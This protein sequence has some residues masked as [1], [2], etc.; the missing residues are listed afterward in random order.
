MEDLK[1][2][3][4][5]ILSMI[6]I[7]IK[8]LNKYYMDYMDIKYT[9]S[10]KGVFVWI[11]ILQHYRSYYTINIKYIYHRILN[12]LGQKMV[13]LFLFYSGY[14]IYE[15]LKKEGIEYSKKLPIKALIFYIK[16]Q[17]ILLIFLLNY[18]ILGVRIKLKKYVLSMFFISDI[19]NSNW[20][21][22]TII[23]F[24]IYCFLSFRLINNNNY[25]FLGIIFITIICAFHLHLVYKY[26]Y[27]NKLY[28]IDNTLCFLLGFYYSFLKKYID[29]ILMKNDCFYYSILAFFTSL[30][31]YF[32]KKL[33]NIYDF[34]IMNGIFSLIIVFI[35]MKIRVNND[36]LLMLNSHSYSI[37]LSQ[38][39]IMI[40]IKNKNYFEYN[41]F[42]RFFI[43]FCAI[44]S[45]SNIFDKYTIIID[46]IIKKQFYKKK[47]LIKNILFEESINII[48][49]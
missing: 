43:E 9:N 7:D 38:R 40:F 28:S 33:Y 6:N 12:N 31:Y 34:L 35:S 11:I 15:S 20:F 39:I 47:F 5:I 30:F 22:F 24:Y 2:L 13:S 45:L 18:I 17:L 44:L 27:P 26:F 41:E 10:I 16:F 42:L 3:I 49:K 23:V 25:N 29:I 19:G 32:N 48:N 4:L 8:G 37:Y 46:K 14:G 1:F 21:A 36:F